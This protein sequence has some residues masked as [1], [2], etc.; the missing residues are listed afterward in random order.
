M[1][2]NKT[3]YAVKKKLNIYIK[4]LFILFKKNRVVNRC[5]WLAE[6]WSLG[7]RVRRQQ[8]ERERDGRTERVTWV[9]A[10]HN[11]PYGYGYA[12]ERA[13]K[14]KFHHE[15]LVSVSIEM[16]VPQERKK[17]PPLPLLS[18]SHALD[19]IHLLLFIQRQ[20]RPKALPETPLHHPSKSWRH[21]FK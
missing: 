5:K 2:W 15:R 6:W 14:V 20:T 16:G 9:G 7:Y 1:I 8:R 17:Q 4:N 3:E 13:K 11:E 18:F 12:C 21:N 19:G 10:K